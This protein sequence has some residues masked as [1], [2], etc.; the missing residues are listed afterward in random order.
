MKIYT[1]TGDNGE[2]GLFGGKKVKKNN[3]R[4]SAYGTIDE[5]NSLLGLVVSE[6]PSDKT[7]DIIANIQYVLFVLGA[8]L[9]T[10]NDFK[11]KK[12]QEI[13][14]K[15]IT[16]L[17]KEIDKI[18]EEIPP[19]KFFI[20]PGGSKPASLLHLARTV[21]R[22]G[23]RE[24]IEIED[25]ISEKILIY[26]NRLSDLLFVMARYENHTASTREIE[27]KPRG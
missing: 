12:N 13:T 16:Y 21:C 23:E 25:D 24:I 7:K 11:S 17:E 6:N 5:L 26:V 9:A 4:I 18:D 19:L 1:K 22:R 20:L 10:P 15:D 14:D 3:P 27:W 2:T 8:E